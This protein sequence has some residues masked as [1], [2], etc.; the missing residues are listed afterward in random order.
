MSTEQINTKEKK[1]IR[2]GR[3]RDIEDCLI[4]YISEG[5]LDCVDVIV[6]HMGTNNVSDGDSVHAIIDDYRNLI[7][8]VRQSLPRTE[9]VISSILPR[10]THYQAN[11]ELVI[12]YQFTDDS[13]AEWRTLD[14]EANNTVLNHIDTQKGR[15]GL[16]LAGCMSSMQ[17]RS[18]KE[19]LTAIANEMEDS[20]E[21]SDDEVQYSE[22]LQHPTLSCLPCISKWDPA[23]DLS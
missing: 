7:C 13:P 12:P 20:D 22:I 19:Y 2:G 18:K 10:P 23:F 16:K 4:Q 6:V 14:E 5:K 11:Q 21:S 1:T 3:I 15:R 17:F 8:T 9:L